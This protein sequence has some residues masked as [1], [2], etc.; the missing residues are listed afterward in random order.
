[1]EVSEARRL[2]Q[3]EDENNRLR[4]VLAESMMDVPTL[5]EMLGKNY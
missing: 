4:K 2:T 5:R 3:P 1:M